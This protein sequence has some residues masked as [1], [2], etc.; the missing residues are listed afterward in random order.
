M[1]LL[2]GEKDK[3]INDANKLLKDNKDTKFLTTEQQDKVKN[4]VDVNNYDIGKSHAYNDEVIKKNDQK[5]KYN[6]DYRS[7][8]LAEI[9][10]LAKALE[11]LKN[12]LNLLSAEEIQINKQWFKDESRLESI[13]KE[14]QKINSNISDIQY[15]LVIYQKPENI[16]GKRKTKKNKFRRRKTKKNL[17]LKLKN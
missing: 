11:I 5:I 13:A 4:I 6:I 7:N 16:G 9:S 15:Q 10:L 14:K 12:K 1:S 3:I 2:E 8:K 17:K